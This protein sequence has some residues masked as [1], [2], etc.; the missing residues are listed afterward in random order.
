MS[1]VIGKNAV[2]IVDSDGATHWLMPGDEVP[3]WA[4]KQVGNH[5]L[6]G[7]EE[8][9]PAEEDDEAKP[10]RRGRP[11]KGASEDG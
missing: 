3:S 6:A 7:A 11:P 2:Y 10:P 5:C 4:A 8:P 9:E 1:K